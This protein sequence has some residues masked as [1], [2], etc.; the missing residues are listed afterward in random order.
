LNPEIFKLVD[1][2]LLGALLETLF[3]ISVNTL[4]ASEE[5]VDAI[6]GMQTYNNSPPISGA[7][8]MTSSAFT[9]LLLKLCRDGEYIFIFDTKYL[10]VLY[11]TGDDVPLSYESEINTPLLLAT[12][13]LW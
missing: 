13:L 11:T 10:R 2:F 5:L 1:S 9:V 6:I 3:I 4:E 8:S 12:K 7:C